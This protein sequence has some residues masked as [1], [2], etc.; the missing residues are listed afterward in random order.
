M[1]FLN[2][3]SFHLLNEIFAQICTLRDVLSAG[4]SYGC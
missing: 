2:M 3:F 1:I 4:G